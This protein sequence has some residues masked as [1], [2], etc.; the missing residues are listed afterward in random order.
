[1][2]KVNHYLIFFFLL[3]GTSVK[4]LAEDTSQLLTL[5][6]TPQER[7][8]INSNRYKGDSQPRPVE[9]QTTRETNAVSSLVKEEVSVRYQISG[10]STNTEGS[11]TAWV[12]GKPYESGDVM[13]DGSKIRIRNSTVIIT[14]A[15]GK[16]HSALSGEVLDLTFL[17]A[18]E[19]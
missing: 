9:V 3:T 17:R 10:I 5:F 18:V 19:Q 2:L 14:T 4:A 15:D 13:D 12:N 11:K 7:Q 8:L 16:S 6:T 1:M